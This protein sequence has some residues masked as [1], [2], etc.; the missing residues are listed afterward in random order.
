MTQEQIQQ[1]QARA[2]AATEGPWKVV[3][4]GN[5]VKSVAV[6]TFAGAWRPQEMICPNMSPKTVNA[7][8]IAHAR[9]DIP[10]LLSYIAEL[11]AERD[12]MVEDMYLTARNAC[13]TCESNGERE[14]NCAECQY[15]NQYEYRGVKK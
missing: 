7:G 5:T 8:F 12:E 14:N 1:I 4:K 6:T 13:Y 10:E 15:S 11:E 3:D 2:D 9:Q